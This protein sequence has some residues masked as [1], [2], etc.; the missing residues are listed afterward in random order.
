MHTVEAEYSSQEPRR[1]R[2]AK[3]IERAQRQELEDGMRVGK[4]HSMRGYCR[5]D[6]IVQRGD[7]IADNRLLRWIEHEIWIREDGGTLEAKL[8]VEHCRDAGQMAFRQ[9]MVA[10]EEADEVVSVQ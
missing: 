1:Q 4:S 5:S 8:H 9:P 10:A 2:P 6:D 3:E 7:M